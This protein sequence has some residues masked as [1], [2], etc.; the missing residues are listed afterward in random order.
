M[1]SVGR[2]F[3]EAVQKMVPIVIESLVPLSLFIIVVS[4]FCALAFGDYLTEVSSSLEHHYNWFWLILTGDTLGKLLPDHLFSNTLY[5]FFFF[6]MIYIGQKFLL[7]LILGATFDTF[8]SMTEKQLKKEKVKE[9]QGLVKA[10]TAIDEYATGKI[11]MEVIFIFT[12]L[13]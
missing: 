7:S 13:R 5:Q 11:S 12:L 2:R 9:L 6:A 10:F 3:F 4:I 1:L 8:K